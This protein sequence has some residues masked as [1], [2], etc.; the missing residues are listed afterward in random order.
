MS[1]MPLTRSRLGEQLTRRLRRW[2]ITA[3]PIL[4]AAVAPGLSWLVAVQVVE[5]RVPFF[6]PVAAVVSLELTLGQRLRRAM[7][8]IVGVAL[9]I[10]V[11]D[12]SISEIR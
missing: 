11:G 8:L 10:V 6:A 2:R 5:H 4:Q 1:I 3:V 7:E 12:L 9:S